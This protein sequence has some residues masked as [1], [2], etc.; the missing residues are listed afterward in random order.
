MQNETTGNEDGKANA[1]DNKLAPH[2]MNTTSRVYQ[3]QDKLLLRIATTPSLE[4]RLSLAQDV[5][6]PQETPLWRPGPTAKPVLCNACGLRWRTKETL[7]DY[8]PK[9][10]SIE[11][12]SLEVGEEVS[13]QDGSSACLEEEM[14]NISSLGSAG[15]SPDKCMQM[16]EINRVQSSSLPPERSLDALKGPLKVHLGVH[17]WE[18]Q[19]FV[20]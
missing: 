2:H 4:S 20:R 16:E 14:I 1:C 17:I 7:D 12:P 5:D 19:G 8:L 15:S 13:G 18:R 11:L 9:H 10:A 6:V 3:P